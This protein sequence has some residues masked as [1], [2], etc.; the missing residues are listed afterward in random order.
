MQKNF[1]E[2]ISSA[3]DWVAMSGG[4]TVVVGDKYNIM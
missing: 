3:W 2:H 4:I 1:L